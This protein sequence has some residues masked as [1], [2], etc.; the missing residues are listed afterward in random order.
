M[1]FKMTAFAA[2]TFGLLLANQVQAD[3][4]ATVNSQCASCHAVEKPDFATLGKLERLERKGPPLYFAGN[5][6]REG[7]LAQW[8]QKPQ[9][10]YL[11][12]Y[13]PS[14]AVFQDTS[15]GE[16]PDSAALLKH[17]ALNAAT[18]TEVATYLMSLQPKSEL[19]AAV[20]YTPGKVAKR[21]GTMNFRKFKA[22]DSCHQDALDEGGFSGPTLYNAWQRLQPEFIVSFI[23]DPVAWDANTIM[24]VMEM[25]SAAVNKLV[26]YLKLIGGEE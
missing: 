21:M 26:D 19:I 1:L 14:G 6:Y 11:S 20:Q 17:V 5:K 4:A 23:Q 18:A 24:P 3:G 15:E 16:I 25:N 7:W 10:H 8:L 12:G 22:C 2:A 13:F 9:N